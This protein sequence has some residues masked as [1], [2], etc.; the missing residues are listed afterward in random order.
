[1]DYI[2][3]L[4]MIVSLGA[5]SAVAGDHQLNDERSARERSS[6]VHEMKTKAVELGYDISRLEKALAIAQDVLKRQGW[7]IALSA[8]DRLGGLKVTF[9]KVEE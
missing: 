2:L 8:P 7:R 6:S 5:G 3:A 4:T 1:M 9:E